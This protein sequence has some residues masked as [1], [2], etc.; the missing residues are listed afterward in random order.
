MHDPAGK[1]YGARHRP[2]LREASRLPGPIRSP[3]LQ[4]MVLADRGWDFHANA[5]I[6]C[7]DLRWVPRARDFFVVAGGI[8]EVHECD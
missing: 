3:A 2:E 5:L 8:E 4:R 6:S 7:N 1:R